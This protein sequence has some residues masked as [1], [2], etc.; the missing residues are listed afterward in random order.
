MTVRLAN[1]MGMKLVAEYA[2][3]FGIYDKMPPVLAMSLGFGRDD[4][5][6]HGLGLFGD[7]QWRQADQADR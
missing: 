5:D 6:A 3:R 4:R 2:E 7:G 1:D